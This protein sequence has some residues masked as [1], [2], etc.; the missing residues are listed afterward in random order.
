MGEPS[1]APGR[2]G[3]VDADPRRIVDPNEVVEKLSSVI[4]NL[5]WRETHQKLR[6][7]TAFQWLKRQLTPRQQADILAL[8]IPALA[9]QMGA[10]KPAKPAAAAA[11][12]KAPTPQAPSPRASSPRASSPDADRDDRKDR[13]DLS[14][15]RDADD[16]RRS[17]E[18]ERQERDDDRD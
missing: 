6:S 4:P 2:L 13:E 15:R 3:D 1:G 14:E 18:D 17:G 7:K 5:D 8:G 11:M 12:S 9:G 10:A 16:V